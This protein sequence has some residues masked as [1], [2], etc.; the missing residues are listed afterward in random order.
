MMKRLVKEALS[1]LCLV[2]SVV[3]CSQKD[4]EYRV[5]PGYSKG[6]VF[7]YDPSS[8][9]LTEAHEAVIELPSAAGEMELSF[10]SFGLCGP[11]KVSGP[12]DIAVEAL[13]KSGS[14]EGDPVYGEKDGMV[15]YIQKMT[16]TY[17]NKPGKADRTA[18]YHVVGYNG[19]DG[20]IA[21][22]TLKQ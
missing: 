16:V 8:G 10:V 1:A 20:V 2:M 9:T 14:T 17:G 13:Y 12:D 15:Q 6:V 7:L 11:I 18:V 21:E 19:F 4:E 22:F 5:G 3:S